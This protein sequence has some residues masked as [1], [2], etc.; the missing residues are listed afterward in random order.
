MLFP[1]RVQLTNPDPKV[2][3]VKTQ[4]RKIGGDTDSVEET[5][6]TLDSVKILAGIRPKP[7]RRIPP[8]QFVATL[9]EES[10]EENHQPHS[11]PISTSNSSRSSVGSS[12]PSTTEPQ[13]SKKNDGIGELLNPAPKARKKP[14]RRR[15]VG[16]SSTED[17]EDNTLENVKILAGIRPKQTR[18]IAAPAFE[19]NSDDST[20]EEVPPPSLQLSDTAIT[21]ENEDF[22]VPQISNIPLKSRGTSVASEEAAAKSSHPTKQEL[23]QGKGGSSTSSTTNEE[24]QQSK[25]NDEHTPESESFVSMESSQ[26]QAR[27]ADPVMDF[28]ITLY[29]SDLR[30]YLEDCR[31]HFFEVTDDQ[32]RVYSHLASLTGSGRASSIEKATHIIV[33]PG[34]YSST[35]MELLKEAVQGDREVVR[36]DWL[37]ACV[38]RQA[39][40]DTEEYT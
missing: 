24:P 10:D 21:N 8:P 37:I 22:V 35:Q 31:L 2:R 1:N 14:Q 28:D 6:N 13:Q 34:N 15:I 23:K 25:K 9:E 18:H 12:S 11:S 16:F 5:D 3:K 36:S 32:K 20:A 26:N 7:T 17:E 40:L 33:P 27:I 30:E 39:K 4:R 29:G 19:T 38:Q